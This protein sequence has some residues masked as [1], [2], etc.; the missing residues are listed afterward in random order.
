MRP[1][2]RL[3]QSAQAPLPCPAARR[4]GASNRG[5]RVTGAR[6]ERRSNDTG[7]SAARGPAARCLFRRD[8]RPKATRRAVASLPVFRCD[9]TASSGGLLVVHRAPRSRRA[10][11]LSGR[12]RGVSAGPAV[13]TA[14]CHGATFRDAGNREPTAQLSGWDDGLGSRVSY[15]DRHPRLSCA[16][17]PAAPTIAGPVLGLV[18]GVF[19][20]FTGTGRDASPAGPDHRAPCASIAAA[21]VYGTPPSVP[22][23]V[24]VHCAMSLVKLLV[25]VPVIVPA[26]YAPCTSP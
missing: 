11:S 23:H 4:S 15:F 10:T 1:G 19:G 5:R 12:L 2:D 13:G 16:Q 3:P 24:S 7:R 14:A 22:F 8:A 9:S 26:P 18:V 17:Q 6:V 25:Q 20:W 21:S